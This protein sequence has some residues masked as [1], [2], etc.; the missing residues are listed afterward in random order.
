MGFFSKVFKGIKK[1][2]KGIF[3]GIKKVVKPIGKLFKQVLKPF[4]KLANK[5]GPIG[6]MAL[7]FIAPYALP[8]IWGTFGTWAAGLTG[9][10]AGMM[11][12]IHTAGMA[13]GKAYTTVT[14]FISDTVGRIAS[15]TIGKIPL[16]QGKTVGS[17]FTNF[18][19]NMAMRLEGRNL[20]YGNNIVDTTTGTK[21]SGLIQA[22]KLAADNI[23]LIKDQAMS[24]TLSQSLSRFKLESLELPTNYSSAAST[25][26]RSLAFGEQ[27]Q[28][29]V[30]DISKSLNLTTFQD[31]VAAATQPTSLL[32]PSGYFKGS[33]VEPTQESTRKIITGLNHEHKLGIDAKTMKDVK[34]DY[35]TAETKT[36]PVS[37]LEAN[38][39]IA[40]NHFRLQEYQATVNGY[41]Q[42]YLPVDT[43]PTKPID[44][45]GTTLNQ[46]QSDI[47]G[48]AGI[49]GETEQ[50]QQ[51]RQLDAQMMDYDALALARVQQP[52][53]TDYSSDF[54]NL[55]NQYS[56]AGY[57][58][59]T[60]YTSLSNQYS[61]GAYGGA[62]FM[63]Q[64]S[65][66]FLQPTIGM[67]RMG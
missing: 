26:D 13:I 8:A 1:G 36:V 20:N 29:G 48:V 47:T 34:L 28:A 61:A 7:M 18:K 49:V 5:L 42:P 59:E 64:V 41:A 2:I 14:G 21:S 43:G 35:L 46:L 11:Q 63:S 4:G 30:T 54:S 38:P 39:Q 62:G 45:F 32:S 22:E 10:M 27:L 12:G 24:D 60:D 16:G 55:S 44:K 25:F 52:G 33:I 65:S 57:G 66:R 58:P 31:S 19:N 9:P 51:Q 15:N 53:L 56:A 50:E 37:Y 6:T 3:K 17:V 23:N 67:P 40:N